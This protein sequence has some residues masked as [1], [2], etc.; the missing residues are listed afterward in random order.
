M[1][2]DQ[3]IEAY[4]A[5]LASSA[6]T[7]GGGAAAGLSGAQAAALMAMVCNLTKN[8]ESA[9]GAICTQA[10][11]AQDRFAALIDE[12]MAGFDAVMKVYKSPAETDND[13][14]DE[15]LQRALVQAAEAPLCMMETASTLIAPLAKLVTIGNR[16]LITDVG[17]AGILI[18][19]T[20]QTARLNVLIN[21]KSIKDAAV[22]KAMIER[23]DRVMALN[24]QVDAIIQQTQESIRS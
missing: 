14:R 11:A 10:E 6:A 12:D 8:N 4:L 18:G 15:A 21:L 22:K 5:E 17:V 16:N 1:I 2:R 3:T 13:K 23:V 7:P 9:I 19:A 20:I 24:P